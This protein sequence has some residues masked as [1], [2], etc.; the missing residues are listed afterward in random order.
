MCNADHIIER[1]DM[2]DDTRNKP[3]MNTKRE[4]S[5]DGDRMHIH[6]KNGDSNPDAVTT[7]FELAYQQANPT[8]RGIFDC[9]NE[10]LWNPVYLSKC[11]ANNWMHLTDDRI[12]KAASPKLLEKVDRAWENSV[13]WMSGVFGSDVLPLSP[14]DVLN[15]MECTALHEV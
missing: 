10:L 6:I 5:L 7:K 2:N 8:T 3:W 4:Q 13:T 9:P 15:T 1:P 12:M 11:R 14:A